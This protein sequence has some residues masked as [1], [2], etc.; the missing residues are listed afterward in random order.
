M[1]Q[2]EI[3]RDIEGYEGQYQVSNLG[4]VKSFDRID[5]AGHLKRG[6]ILR[7][8]PD[9]KGYLRVQLH[10]EGKR[11]LFLVHRLVAQAF[12]P[13]PEGL[14]Q[15]N[16]RDEDPSNARADNLEWCTA[17]YNVNYGTH[18]ERMIQ[19]KIS[20]GN[21]D[22]DMCGVIKDGDR[23]E[24][25]QMYYQK[26]QEKI[27]ECQHKNRERKLEYNHMYYQKNR[28]QIREQNK[29]YYQKNKEKIIEHHREYRRR[30]KITA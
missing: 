3:W 26:N 15:V 8:V 27:L 18:N 20:N 12:I 6:R 9:K 5:G 21:A 28:D 1:E 24:Y 19:T 14:P 11:K 13:N 4:R 10:K 23:R 16:H 22:P 25:N 7:P 29:D 2:E 30:K 17:S